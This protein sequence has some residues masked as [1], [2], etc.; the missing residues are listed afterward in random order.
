MP[1]LIVYLTISYE[2]LYKRIA[3]NYTMY[4]NKKWTYVQAEG[5]AG[6]YV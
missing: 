4:T 2:Q 3:R 5:A 6:A 1:I